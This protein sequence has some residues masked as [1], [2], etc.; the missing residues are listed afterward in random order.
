MIHGCTI[1][2]LEVH[3]NSQRAGHVEGQKKR[4]IHRYSLKDS[5]QDSCSLGEYA[6]LG[7]CPFLIPKR[8]LRSVDRLV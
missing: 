2:T 6:M 8:C 1:C 7:G 3:E 5:Y 4:N